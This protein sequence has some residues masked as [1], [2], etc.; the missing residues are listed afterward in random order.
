MVSI[1]LSIY[2]FYKVD[3][4]PK[5]I[6]WEK[7]YIVSKFSVVNGKSIV[8]GIRKRQ[9]SSRSSVGIDQ[10]LKAD[11]DIFHCFIE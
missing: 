10:F 4:A 8:F 1:G 3:T 7:M 2:K 11:R 5:I 9:N 6:E